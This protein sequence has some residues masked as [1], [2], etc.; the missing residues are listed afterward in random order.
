MTEKAVYQAAA[1]P[2]F[3]RHR[4]DWLGSAPCTVILPEYEDKDHVARAFPYLPGR[5][6]TIPE[7]LSSYSRSRTGR[8][9]VSPSLVETILNLILTD[10]RVPY[11]KMEKFRHSYVRALADFFT[12]FRGT[13]LEDLGQALEGL[14]GDGLSFKERDLIKIY[15]EYERRLP[16]YGHDLRSGLKAFLQEAEEGGMHQCLG[17]QGGERV[18]FLGFHYFTPVEAAFIRHVFASLPRASL[19]LL[20]E[21]KASEQAMRIGRTAAPL[22]EALKGQGTPH[23]RL[24]SQSSPY[25]TALANHLFGPGAGAAAPAEGQKGR[26]YITTANSRHQEVVSIARRIREL[27]AAG[28]P[29]GEVRLVAPAYDLYTLIV[30]EVFPEYGLPY[31][32]DLGLPLLRFPLARVIRQLV[33][34]GVNANPFPAREKILSS[35]YVR[36]REEVTPEKLV[37]YQASCG[38]EMLGEEGLARIK[39]GQY[40]LDFAYLKTLRRESY[41]AVNPLP[42]VP[43]LEVAKRYLK[44][45]FGED[46]GDLEAQLARC[47]LQSYLAQRAEAALT[48]WPARL[49]EEDFVRILRRLLQRF[50]VGENLR[51]DTGTGVGPR[52]AVILKRVQHLLGEM[53][54]FPSAGLPGGA[55]SFP[56]LAR[57]FSR[58]LEEAFLKEDT[59]REAGVR[60]QPAGWGQYEPWQHTFVCGLV[61][62]EFPAVEE[63]NFLE[64]KRDGLALGQSCTRVDHGRKDFYHLVRSTTGTLYLSRPLSDNG[65]R[66]A[67]SPFIREVEKCLPGGGA[68]S[69]EDKGAGGEA[70]LYSLREKLSFIGR[71]VDRDYLQAAPLLKELREADP[72]YQDH[73]LEVLRYDGL[74]LGSR[75]SEYDGLFSPGQRVFPA[76]ELL[77]AEIRKMRFTPQDLERYAACPLRYFFDDILHLRQ[78]PDYNPDTTEAGVLVR[79]LLQ[80]YTEAACRAGGVPADAEDRF[81]ESVAAHQKEQ[82]EQGLD[83]FQTRF[84]KSLA[85]GLGEETP[86]RRGLLKAFLQYEAEGPDFLTPVKSSLKGVLA[87]GGGELEVRVQVDRVDRAGETGKVLAF[88]YTLVGDGNTARINRGLRFDLPLAA[89]LCRQAFE[90]GTLPGPVAGAGY[91]QVKTARSIRRSGYFASSSIRAKRRDSTSPQVPVFSGSPTGFLEEEE[92]LEPLEQVQAHIL[93]LYRL[94]QRGVFHLPLCFAAE[95]SCRNCSFGRLCRKDQ[96]RLEKMRKLLQEQEAGEEEFHLVREIF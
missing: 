22:L 27:A 58:L 94:M 34:Q 73:I 9:L 85:A 68:G 8:G 92:F 35:P 41:L 1:W 84:L 21:E 96:L 16:G 90:E 33:S 42:G 82:E 29:L 18:V 45:F 13:T 28:T 7:L 76:R 83:A 49:K 47:L 46:P 57:H 26:V 11:L 10:S 2:D 20:Q 3:H 12:H 89:L 79:A 64:P 38:V 66:L 70:G 93:R 24:P 77:A 44:G 30:G 74:T 50:E 19:L 69:L 56:E 88:L 91:Y 53:Q 6:A 54:L 59:G 15:R 55:P 5:A 31:T 67:A 52:D 62:G 60:V 32:P 25:F 80:G 36:F 14:R 87:P 86:R 4:G 63:F 81:L 17:L 95:Q 78:R 23:H 65:K 39:P 61:D 71:K 40:S 72:E 48:C 75:F 51:G 43:P 37:A